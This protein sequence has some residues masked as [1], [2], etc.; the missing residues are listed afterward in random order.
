MNEPKV[1]NLGDHIGFWLRC[2]SNFV[3]NNFEEKLSKEDVTVAQWVVLRTLYDHDHITLNQLAELIGLDKSSVSRMIERLVLRELVNRSKGNDRRSL[4][5]SL[6]SAAR[7]LVP[8]LAKLAD[9]NDESF[10]HSLPARKRHEFLATIKQLL[11]ANG[12]TTSEC[13][14]YGIG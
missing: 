6:T 12:W 5:L 11:D 9:Q 14:R 10:F 4:G 1:S 2:L 13:G 8:R 3:S 7:K